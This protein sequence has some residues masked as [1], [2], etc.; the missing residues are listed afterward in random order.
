M[1]GP[2]EPNMNEKTY[3]NEN[4]YEA[5][6]SQAISE[7]DEAN[8]R[9]KMMLDSTPIACFLVRDDVTCI[10][11]NKEA[12]NLF[13][14]RDKAHAVEHFRDIFPE[15]LE[16]NEKTGPPK[17]LG[18]VK[19][20]E[21]VSFEFTHKSVSTGELIPSEVTLHRM[22]YRD[23]PVIAAYVRDLREIRAMLSEMR[24]IDIAE[25]ESRAKSQFLARMSH[26]IRTPMNAII[27]ITDIQLR[28]SGLDPL[29]EEAFTYIR[30]S[31]N[32]LL[33]II[34]DILDLSKVEAGKM[35]VI[36][37]PYETAGLIFDTAQL[38][39]SQ[40]SGNMDVEFILDIDADLPCILD[41][42]EIRIK[43]ILNN[44]FSNAFKYTSRGEIKAC[45]RYEGGEF[46]IQVRDTGQGMTREQIDSLW[47]NEYVRFNELSNR[48]IEGTGL[49]MNITN[50]LVGMMNGTIKA[51]SVPGK[52]TTF[53]I[54]LPQKVCS[55]DC[56]GAETARALEYMIPPKRTF[57]KETDVEYEPMP[58]GK[59]LV[60]DDVESNLYVAKGLLAAYSLQ[61]D[62]VSSGRQAIEL[63]R[64]GREYDIIFMDHM[65]PEMD[66]IQAVKIIRDMG[67]K[68]PIVALTANTILGQAELFAKN[69]FSSFISKPINIGALHNCVIRF[70]KDVHPMAN[71]SVSLGN[72]IGQA[73][74]K[75]ISKLVVD[76]FIRDAKKAVNILSTLLLAPDFGALELESYTI[77]VHGTKSALGNV[78]EN[79][80]SGMARA[81]EAFGRE[82]DV[83]GIK[84]KTP[85]FL[86]ELYDVITKY[87]NPNK[88][89]A[90]AVS[91]DVGFLVVKL[92]EVKKACDRLNKKAAKTAL[93]A[94]S[95]LSWSERTYKLIDEVGVFLLHSE[96]D[97]ASEAI[98]KFL[99]TLR[100]S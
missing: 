73:E 34:N 1:I 38:V 44:I 98:G 96:F 86:S 7:R 49:G 87:E 12:V 2:V 43:Q 28:K 27:G 74:K 97:E 58:Y 40:F 50:G 39:L 91:E 54:R 10:D 59:V 84:A 18:W 55:P 29:V 69:G 22:V 42:D 8:V 6:I 65:M 52:G 61:I 23:E 92:G 24:R 11:C 63:V 32:I 62:T 70:V 4:D 51:E 57:Q 82:G 26:E 89:E 20:D 33:S 35:S 25:K 85:Q 46:V 5:I 36:S 21:H 41:G 45:F 93:A 94:L 81:L 30:S 66:G 75:D 9:A 78:G 80:L 71:Q 100:S 48:I 76:S 37:A 90:P 83:L 19:A 15:F 53:E 99:T 16:N 67:Y 95:A 64:G 13:G 77:T 79:D 47:S 3:S 60:V 31:S 88:N 68:K 17:S 14:F 56:L 72:L